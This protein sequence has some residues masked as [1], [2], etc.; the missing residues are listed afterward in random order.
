MPLVKIVIPVPSLVFVVNAIVGFG[1]VLQQTPFPVIV[2]PPELEMFPPELAV[3]LVID[4]IVVVV[5]IGIAVR[6]LKVV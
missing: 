3:E 4:E 1:L 2:A 5:I 6:A